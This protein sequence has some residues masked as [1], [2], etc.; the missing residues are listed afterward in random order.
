MFPGPQHLFIYDLIDRRT[1]GK[2]DRKAMRGMTDGGV[3]QD[4]KD[5]QVIKINMPLNL[6]LM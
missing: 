2:R 4:P 1:Q 3:R 6:V 5:P